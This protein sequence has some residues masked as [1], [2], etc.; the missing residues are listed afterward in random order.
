[1]VLWLDL[2]GGFGVIPASHHCLIVTGSA[3]DEQPWSQTNVPDSRKRIGLDHVVAMFE[4]GAPLPTCMSEA[5]EPS[6]QSLH[7][8]FV[9][10]QN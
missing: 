1:M 9:H 7:R 2:H 10:A 5:S 8:G 3:F 4:E 6:R